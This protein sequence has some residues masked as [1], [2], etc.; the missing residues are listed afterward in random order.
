MLSIDL[1]GRFELEVALVGIVSIHQKNWD[2][3]IRKQK[4]IQKTFAKCTQPPLIQ[5]CSYEH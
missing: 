5:A 4:L 2:A 3:D 1:S